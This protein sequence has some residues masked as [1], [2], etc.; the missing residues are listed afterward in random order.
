MQ[1]EQQKGGMSYQSA[2][3]PRLHFGLGERTKVNQIEVRWPSGTEDLIKDVNADRVV[4]IREGNGR[5]ETVPAVLNV[6]SDT[7]GRAEK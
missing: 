2:H 7:A 5:A 1:F 4:V 3:D 6:P